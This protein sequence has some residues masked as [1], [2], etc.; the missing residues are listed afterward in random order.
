FLDHLETRNAGDKVILTVKRDNVTQDIAVTLAKTPPDQ[1]NV[2]GGTKTRPYAERLG[3]QRANVQNRQ[4]P[5]GHEYRG[6]YRSTDGGESWTRV[7]SVNPRPMYFSVIR[8]DPT[9]NRYLYVLGISLY[10]SR[11]G[12]KTFKADGSRGVHAD[13]HA[14][15]I[16][17]KDGR[18]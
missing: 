8:V 5:D 6:V 9:D 14:L 18:H 4:G 13:Q 16:N 10:R 3:A 12:G 17:P 1:P 15:W 11:D 7:N 2:F